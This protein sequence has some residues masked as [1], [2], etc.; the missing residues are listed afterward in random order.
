[1][2]GADEDGGVLGEVTVGETVVEGVTLGVADVGETVGVVV[3]VGVTDG[4]GVALGV[5]VGVYEGARPGDHRRVHEALASI[6][7]QD[8]NPDEAA[9]HRAAAS[10]VPDE[11]VAADLERSAARAER[12]G[13]WLGFAAGKAV[14]DLAWYGV[15]PRPAGAWPG[16]SRPETR[17]PRPQTEMCPGLAGAGLGTS[18]R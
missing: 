4:V 3:A 11:Y 10:V 5:A 1:M 9:W 2:A 7:G 18:L 13:V 6:A 12:R 14:A 15:E 8:G 16:R 17:Q